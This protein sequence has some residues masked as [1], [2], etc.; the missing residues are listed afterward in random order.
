MERG[1]QLAFGVAN[2]EMPGELL[3]VGIDALKRRKR[4]VPSLQR[5]ILEVDRRF[6]P[7]YAGSNWNFHPAC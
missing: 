1:L 4:R 5:L 7:L 6:I 3:T 2:T